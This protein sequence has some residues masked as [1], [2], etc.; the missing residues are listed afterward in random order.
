MLLFSNSGGCSLIS[1]RLFYAPHQLG[2]KERYKEAIREESKQKCT[3]VQKYLDQL[4]VPSQ[5]RHLIQTLWHLFQIG[6]IGCSETYSNE[7]EPMQ[8]FVVFQTLLLNPLVHKC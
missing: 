1:V 6:Y 7:Y 2:D 8:L 3:E 5:V 4:F